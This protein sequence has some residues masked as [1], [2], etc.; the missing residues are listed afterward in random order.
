MTVTGRCTSP[1][2]SLPPS[3]RPGEARL[4]EAGIAVEAHTTWPRG[5]ESIYFRDPDNHLVELA[6]PGL[7]PD[8]ESAILRFAVDRHDG[9]AGDTVVG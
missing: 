8:I 4:A 7:W 9:A 3:A 2:Q 5:G 1:L 6:T